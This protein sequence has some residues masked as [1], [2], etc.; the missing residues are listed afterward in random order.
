MLILVVSSISL[1]AAFVVFPQALFFF[2]RS[3][4][5]RQA[6]LYNIL[7]ERINSFDISFTRGF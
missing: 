3:C 2:Y 1:R 4:R 5:S 7:Q 6:P